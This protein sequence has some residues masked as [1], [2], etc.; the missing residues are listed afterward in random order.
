M[1]A[2]TLLRYVQDHEG[3]F[4]ISRILMASNGL[5]AVKG[6][7]SIRKWS[8]ETFGDE[9][10]IFTFVVLATTDDIEANAEFIKLAD[11]YIE[12]SGGP[13]SF[14]YANVDL[15]VS[16]AAKHRVHVLQLL[17]ST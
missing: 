3:D 12:V 16:L 10:C 6:I 2:G 17:S 9:R 1:P 5:A 4:A 8:L 14:N 7:R 11:E 13:N 15:I